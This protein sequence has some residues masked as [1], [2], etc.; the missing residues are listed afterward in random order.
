MLCCGTWRNLRSVMIMVIVGVSRLRRSRGLFA[1]Y[2]G[3][4]RRGLMRFLLIFEKVLAGQVWW[5]TRLF[6]I[7][8]RAGKMLE[9]WRWS[10]M[11][12]LYKNK[13]DIQS[14]NNYR[15]IKLL[16]HTMKIWER[17]V[18]L[19]LRRIMTISENQSSFMPGRSTMEAIHL[20]RRLVKQFWERKKNLHMIFIDLE[21]HIAE[22]L[23][24]F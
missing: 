13:G 6:N 24:R 9:T 2:V 5:L 3:V 18:E 20:V 11:I 15:G 4:G 14:C 1:R 7:I 17:V 10:T 8:F 21:K 23:G 16:S 12:P 19:R 22:F